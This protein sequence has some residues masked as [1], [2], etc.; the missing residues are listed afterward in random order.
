MALLDF[1]LLFALVGCLASLYF[2][3]KEKRI[4]YEFVR[5]SRRHTNNREREILMRRRSFIYLVSSAVFFF[6]SL[7]LLI[8]K[9][10]EFY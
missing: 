5:T 7:P 3:F 4:L 2:Y 9:I 10:I 6:I 1:I 8:Q